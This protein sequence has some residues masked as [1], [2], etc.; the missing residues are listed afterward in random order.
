MLHDHNSIGD[1]IRWMAEGPN[2]NVPTFSG[3]KISGVIYST[4]KR[5]NNRQVQCSG[6]CV[7]ADTLML[8]EK[9]KSVE[10]TSHTYYGVITSI[11]ELDYNNF[12]VPIFRCNWVDMNKGVKVDELGYT[13][14]NLNKL[15]FSN[16]P[17][18]LGKHVKQVCYI[19]D[20][21]EKFWSVV[22]KVP[23]KNFYDHCDDENEGSVEIELENEL[24]LPVFPNV[25][26]LDDENTSYMREEEEWIQLPSW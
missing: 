26:E 4:K 18:V 9:F 8:S 10:H 25:D 16:D 19:D 22:L 15:G 5:D 17:F 3:Y 6:V 23:E 21:L 20:T 14:V 12:R 2:K 11:W 7:V 13:L 1:D 24:Q